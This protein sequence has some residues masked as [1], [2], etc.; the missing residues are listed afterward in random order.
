VAASFLIL[1]RRLADLVSGSA[2]R[3]AAIAMA[4]GI[5]F[6]YYPAESGAAGPD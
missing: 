1:N 2:R 5:F 3:A 4:I 6:G